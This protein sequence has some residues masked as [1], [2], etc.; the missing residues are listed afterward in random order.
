MTNKEIILNLRL[1]A[2]HLKSHKCSSELQDAVEEAI[3]LFG[4][5]VKCLTLDLPCTV[6]DTIWC[7]KGKR[8]IEY[9]I[10]YLVVLANN[11]VHFNC[12][13]QNCIITDHKTFTEDDIGKT[14]FLTKEEANTKIR[15]MSM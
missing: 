5:K 6:G 2:A 10:H 1:A 3:D 13:R 14:I 9:R 7:V 12:K 11:R 8:V 15:G 4:K